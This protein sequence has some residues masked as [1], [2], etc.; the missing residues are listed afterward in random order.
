MAKNTQKSNKTKLVAILF[1]ALILALAIGYAAFGDTLTIQG[2]ANA[3]GKFDLNFVTAE[4]VA[5]TATGVDE[6][7]SSIAI[8]DGGDKVTVNVADLGYPGAGI[9]FHTVIKNE[10]TVPAKV[11]SVT[12]VGLNNEGRAIKVLGLDAITTSHPTIAANGTCTIDFAVV[13]D[14]SAQLADAENGDSVTFSLEVEYEQDTTLS[15][16]TTSH[17]DA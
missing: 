6:T 17:T 15:T 11:K 2:T 9:Q 4:I 1:L 13:W 8:T 3:K 16:A 12:Q 7:E 10:G 5:G 14:Q